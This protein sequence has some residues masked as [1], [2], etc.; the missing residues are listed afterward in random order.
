MEHKLPSINDLY[1][2]IAVK[3]KQ[4]DLNVLLN[5]EPKAE[6]IKQHPI[7]KNVKYIPIE[8]IEWLMTRIFIQWHVEIKMTQVIANSI[9]VTVRLHYKDVL[10]DEWLWQEGLGAAP[11]QTD[12][13][14]GATDFSKVKTDAV[15]KAAPAAESYAIK[16]AAEKIGKIFGKDLNRSDKI[17]YDNLVNNFKDYEVISNGQVNLIESL[18]STSTYDETQKCRIE[19]EMEA[20]TIEEATACIQAL[21]MNQMDAVTEMGKYSQKDLLNINIEKI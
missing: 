1:S 16:D 6:W 10:S 3:S 17:L 5:H 9:V 13:D 19:N 8:R 7:A 11:I 20:Y 14:A 12:K 2:E 18:I 15:M 4:N 21:M